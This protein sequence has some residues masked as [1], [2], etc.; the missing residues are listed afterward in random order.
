[1]TILE[2]NKKLLLM[3][4]HYFIGIGGYAPFSPFMATIAKQR[5]YSA[6]IVGLIFMVQPIP[7][8]FIRPVIGVIT[9]KFKCRRSAFIS[10]TIIIFISI[11]LLSIIP[12]TT[13]KAEINDLDVV[14][15][16]LFWLFFAAIILMAMCDTIK[17]V[18]EETICTSLLGVNKYLYGKQR[19]WGSLGFGI[20]AIISGACVD[21]YSK[22][23][24]YKNY[25][26]A[27]TISLVCF[28]CDIIIVS[29]IEVIQNSSIKYVASDLTKILTKL[30]VRTFLLWA[31]LFGFLM[32]FITH[33][34]FWYLEDLSTIFHP[35]KKSWMKTLQGM[36]VIMRCVSGEVLSFFLSSIILR[37]MDHKTVFSLSFFLFSVDFFLY[38]TIRNPVW[39]L[40]IEVINGFTFGL[41]YSTA[42]SYAAILAPTGSEGTLQGIVGTAICG[43]GTPIGSI[44]GGYMFKH[45]GSLATFKILPIIALI[46]CIAQMTINQLTIRGRKNANVHSQCTLSIETTKTNVDDNNTKF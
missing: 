16:P 25:T 34:V 38:S 45:L 6:V 43:I 13:S 11:W 40:P 3:K 24:E 27:F 26:P 19:L 20:F 22:G 32:A 15:S 33:F 36:S 8:L 1:M 2:I 42:I 30:K 37:Y 17:N 12:G 9:D 46:L 44:V 18:M 4:M 31:V 7:G 29:N 39:A 23:Q 21:W 14:K 35:E 28:F 41:S 5:G 10:S